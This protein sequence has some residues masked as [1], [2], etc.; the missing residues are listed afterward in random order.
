MTLSL[1]PPPTE[2]TY[3]SLEDAMKALNTSAA[4][5]GYAIVKIRSMAYGGVINRVDFEV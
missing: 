3:E 1:A 5:E 4:T 2:G